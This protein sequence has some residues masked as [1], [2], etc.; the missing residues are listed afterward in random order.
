L[1]QSF[2]FLAQP[3]TVP[4]AHRGG[5]LE[6]E[7]NTLP[8]FAR[9]VALGYRDIELDVHA[10]RDGVVVV[11]H[12]ATLARMFGDPR[13]VAAIARDD[14]ARLRTAGGAGLP[15]LAEVLAAF[16]G[17]RFTIEV[18]AAA[19]AEPLARVIRDAGAL[20]RV[21]VG[22]FVP[23][24]TARVRA[25]LGP[26]LCWSPARA[27]V[28]QL[29]LAG[30]GLPLPAPAPVV[31]VPQAFRGIPVVTP[32]FLRAARARGVKVQVW[33]VNEAA[34]IDRLLDWGVDGIMTD[35]PTLLRERMLARGL[36]PG[37]KDDGAGG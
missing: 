6:A 8:A 37:P 1:R 23:A 10:T 4:I 35:R 25:L 30:W 34:D 20:D 15:Q 9:A 17:V 29:W 2:A 32:R 11:H 12:D 24:H 16:P 18:K 21:C 33:T 26:G 28:A 13:P 5:A 31:Q 27:G 3:G 7:E 22:S 36:W 19:A 14:L